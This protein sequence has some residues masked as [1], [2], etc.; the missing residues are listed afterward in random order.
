MPMIILQEQA[1]SY[2]KQTQWKEFYF[3]GDGVSSAMEN[4]LMISI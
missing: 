2:A 3:F 4:Q 1:I